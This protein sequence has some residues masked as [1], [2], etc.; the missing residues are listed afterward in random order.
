MG[1]AG[2]F[3]P[4]CECHGH[5]RYFSPL[6]LRSDLWSQR[7]TGESHH[8]SEADIHCS[9]RISTHGQWGKCT[10]PDK[11]STARSTSVAYI[12]ASVWVCPPRGAAVPIVGRCLRIAFARKPIIPKSGSRAVPDTL[13]VMSSLAEV[14]TFCAR[15]SPERMP[16]SFVLIVQGCY[17]DVME[18]FLEMPKS[19]HWRTYIG[20]RIR[21]DHDQR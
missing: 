21:R 16:G 14:I 6:A 10:I 3:G 9:W 11:R 1:S 15:M 12:R 17:R 8:E 2:L 7:I 4:D 13:R 5:H 19:M 18:A 20:Y